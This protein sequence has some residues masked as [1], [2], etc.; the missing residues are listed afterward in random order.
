MPRD[1]KVELLRSV[2]LFAKLSGHDLERVA[3]LADEVDLPAGR[4][5]MRQ[6]ENGAEAFVLA[7]G[8]ARIER[9]GRQIA[10]RGPGSV[11]GEIALLAETPRTATVTLTEPSTLFVLAHREFHTL[12]G[13]SSSIRAACFEGLAERLR[14]LEIDRVD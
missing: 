5:L 7:R 13:E 11:I 2:P 6:G 8:A 3:Q 10:E 9:D 12:L 14:G 4:V 1:P